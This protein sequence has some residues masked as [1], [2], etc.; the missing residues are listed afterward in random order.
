MNSSFKVHSFN[1]DSYAD[2]F[3]RF[4][5]FSQENN[6]K[7]EYCSSSEKSNEQVGTPGRSKIQSLTLRESEAILIIK[8]L[9]DL[10]IYVRLPY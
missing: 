8:K 6:E 9:E 3:A 4:I 5:C 2:L 10:V 7:I 1:V